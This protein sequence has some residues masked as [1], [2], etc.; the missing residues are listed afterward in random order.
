[1]KNLLITLLISFST[2]VSAQETLHVPSQLQKL[3]DSALTNF[4]RMH[5]LSELVRLS[6]L[7]TDMSAAGYM[8]IVNVDGSYLYLNPTSKVSI[9]LG[10]GITKSLQMNPA[11]NYS[12]MLNVVQPL[13]DFK[14]PANVARAKSDV[15][16][17]EA[18]RES[19][20]SQLAYQVAQ[21]YY[22][23]IFLNRNIAV[24]QLQLSLVKSNLNIIE[25]K[26]RNGDAL[27]YDLV[28]TQVRY[29]NIENSITELQ[30]QLYKQYALLHMLTGGTGVEQ[31]SDTTFSDAMYDVA[32]DSVLGLA[33]RQNHE[34]IIS[35][36]KISYSE[37]DITAIKQIFLPTVNLIGG[38][39]YKNAFAP[40]I[41]DVKFNYDYGISLN[42]PILPGSRPHIQL[43]MAQTGLESAKDELAYQKAALTKDVVNA[44]LEIRKNE[45][46][47]RSMDTLL[48]QAKLA[49]ELG[50]E[51]YKEGVITS[52][53]LLTAETNYQDAL[54][55][56]LQTEYNL[57]LSKLE[58]NRLAGR[59]WW[60]H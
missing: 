5:S 7:K 38:L 32:R 30:T 20:R 59:R 1:M 2:L 58:L 51:R 24:Q 27:T 49:V 12:A 53:E 43:E 60:T 54:L 28:T 15:A 21:L 46:K 18:T 34:L 8:P 39:G 47:Y 26:L 57:L 23:V 37:Y 10:V 33:F 35:Q 50:T 6:N 22:G 11:D 19:Y 48:H 9:P 44:G 4:P 31:I 55:S 36:K 3:T 56:K 29:T 52:V 25:A 42:I 40:N 17:S 14:T 13:L 45:I 41:F 16:I